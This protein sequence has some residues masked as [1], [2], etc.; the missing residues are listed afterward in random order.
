MQLQCSDDVSTV[1]LQFQQTSNLIK[2]L[3]SRIELANLFVGVGLSHAELLLGGW[4]DLAAGIA[5]VALAMLV[6]EES[7]VELVDC[8]EAT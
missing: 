5:M 2:L 6:V 4:V 8:S 1:V 7:L 3:L